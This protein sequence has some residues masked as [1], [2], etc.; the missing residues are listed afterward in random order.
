LTKIFEAR[1]R[2]SCASSPTATSPA[3]PHDKEGSLVNAF[4]IE[5]SPANG[6]R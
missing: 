5:G 1:R 6:T 2:S 3:P 4:C